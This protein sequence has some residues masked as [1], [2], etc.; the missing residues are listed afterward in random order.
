LIGF[1]CKTKKPV[2][3]AA[4]GLRYSLISLAD[5]VQAIAVRRHIGP[6]MVMMT[7]MA[8]LLHLFRK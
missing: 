8:V 1:C 3:L 5:L 7:V 4:G 2:G 6:V